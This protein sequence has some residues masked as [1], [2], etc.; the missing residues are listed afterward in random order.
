MQS[1]T[2]PLNCLGSETLSPSAIDQSYELLIASIAENGVLKPLVVQ[3]TAPNQYRVME[4]RRC[5]AALKRLASDGRMDHEAPIPCE[6]IGGEDAALMELTAKAAQLAI[7]L[8]DQCAVIQRL[9]ADGIAPSDI[10]TTLNLPQSAVIL[11]HKLASAS[12][13]VLKAVRRG[14]LTSDQLLA[15]AVID[16]HAVQERCLE[17]LPDWNSRPYTIRRMLTPSGVSRSDRRA[18]YV[19][20]WAYEAAGGQ[21]LRHAS[22]SDAWGVFADTALVERLAMARLLALRDDLKSEGWEWVEFDLEGELFAQPALQRV[23]CMS[24]DEQREHDRLQAEYDA[25]DETAAPSLREALFDQRQE[26]TRGR[27]HFTDEQKQCAGAAIWISKDGTPGIRRGLIR[28]PLF[29]LDE[30]TGLAANV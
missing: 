15:Y 20:P 21:L 3:P 28:Q 25:L 27:Y 7:D 19:G 16:D 2:I 26:L 13:A 12:P 6:V 4:G 22:E 9:T 23:S 5:L 17:E 8:L 30:A 14:G 29:K 10:A 24:D 18:A 11:G 1:Q